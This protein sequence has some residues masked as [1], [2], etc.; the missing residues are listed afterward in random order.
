MLDAM[1]HD[2]RGSRFHSFMAEAVR[3]YERMQALVEVNDARMPLRLSA[4]GTEKE[5]IA[6]I[7]AT[8]GEKLQK[9]P[10]PAKPDEESS[11]NTEAAVPP[12]LVM[13]VKFTSVEDA[14]EEVH[15]C[16]NTI[17]DPSCE[18]SLERPDGTDTGEIGLSE[19]SLD[20][21][22]DAGDWQKPWV[23]RA[24][25]HF[26]VHLVEKKH[27]YVLRVCWAELRPKN[28]K[29]SL[30]GL[31]KGTKKRD[32]GVGRTHGSQEDLDC[33]I[34]E[35]TWSSSNPL[36]QMQGAQTP[37]ALGNDDI[38]HAEKHRWML[39]P[40]SVCRL[41]WTMIG[42]IFLALDLLYLTLSSFDIER[43]RELDLLDGFYWIADIALCFRTGIFANGEVIMKPHQSMRSYLRGWFAFDVILVAY[44]WIMIGVESRASQASFL[45]YTRFARF[46]KLLRLTKLQ[47]MFYQVL[48]R[49]GNNYVLLGFRLFL[50]TLG[51]AFYVHLSASMWFSVGRI[52]ETGWVMSYEG[53]FAELPLSYIGSFHW[54][55]TQM[56][57][58][59]EIMPNNVRER[60]VSALH[61]M[62]SIIV[63]ALFIS[64]LTTVLQ[65]I[66]D[67][68]ARDSKM[69][70]IAY[71]FMKDNKIRVDL[72]IKL[73]RFLTDKSSPGRSSQAQY[74]QAELL[75]ILPPSLRQALLMELR[76]P[77]TSHALLMQSLLRFHTSFAEKV[78]CGLISLSQYLPGERVFEQGVICNKV[79][80]LELGVAWYLPC[81]PLLG[82]VKDALIKQSSQ[83]WSTWR[84]DYWKRI[85]YSEEEVGTVWCEGSLFVRWIH[86]GDLEAG[87]NTALTLMVLDAQGFEDLVTN[88]TEVQT[89][90]AGHAVRVSTFLAKSTQI[91]D[92][93]RSELVMT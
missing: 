1:A 5:Y 57:G 65:A 23:Y 10:C 7:S 16:T 36:G 52:D 35:A 45:R 8:A 66:E 42:M 29:D 46:M 59:A 38:A 83:M 89:A 76:T 41:V 2:E 24:W 21:P 58:S 85:A 70:N 53:L 84:A 30:V 81:S 44:Q 34:L 79:Y 91:T 19:E 40:D 60:A 28:T 80:F 73:Q 6:R 63:L 78:T 74:A 49:I 47:M 92:Y 86:A 43:P 87:P 69:V 48:Q 55:V 82:H 3:E 77:V 90:L 39:H 51:L 31:R 13:S 64:K 88:F 12:S 14:A 61:Y 62:V 26:M 22:D 15:S 4:A 18:A 75:R 54:A 25:E 72:R 50:Y 68:K 37:P 20:R 33:D 67:I 71:A 27:N 93:F 17:L 56:Q 9:T 32:S 11:R